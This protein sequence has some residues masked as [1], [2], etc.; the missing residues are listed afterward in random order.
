VRER[1]RDALRRRVE[2]GTAAGDVQLPREYDLRR[3]RG[4]ASAPCR[5]YTS[6]PFKATWPHT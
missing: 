5:A 6:M 4:P 3:R 2:A 1:E